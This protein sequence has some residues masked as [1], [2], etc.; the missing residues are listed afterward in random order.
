MNIVI[1]LAGHSRRFLQAGYEI[2]KFLIDIDGV[3]MIQH[4]V[5]MF[6][7]LDNFYFVVNRE[8]IEA[9]PFIPAV[10][11][12]L[13]KKT[14]I[15]IIE[16][17]E[18]G[19]VW[20]ALQVTDIPANDEMIV[21]YCDF[22]VTWDYKQFKR[23][24]YGYD[25][26]VPA[27]RGFHPASFGNTYYAYMR[28][29]DQQEML[30]LREKN[31]FTDK[32]H[33][34]FASAGIYYFSSWTLFKHYAERLMEKGYADS[35]L[36]EGYASLL[37]NP[38]V[39]D[40]YKVKVTEV[41]QF[42]CW[43]TPEDLA[44]YQFWSRYFKSL[45]HQSVAPSQPMKSINLIPM[46]GSGSR[47]KEYGYRVGKPLILIRNKPMVTCAC[48]SFPKADDWIF[49]P[50]QED[51]A[52]H[53][54]DVVIKS[55][56]PQALV[57]P[58]AGNTS[59]Q[60]ATCLLAKND[61]DPDASLFIASCDYEVCFNAAAWQAIVDDETI[62]AVIWTYRMKDALA[63]N[64]MAFAYC[65]TERDSARVKKI[66]EK[67]TISDQPCQDPLVVGSFWFRRA[68]DFIWAAETAVKNNV[69]VNGEHY[70]ANSMNALIEKGDKIVI[71]DVDQWI[72]FGDP[73]ELNVYYY[74]DEYF[75]NTSSR[76]PLNE[77]RI[78]ESQSS[79]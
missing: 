1:T 4:V 5:S 40:G 34:E 26:A 39:N 49:L 77:S 35:N 43:G 32:R 52:K 73:F 6:D 55:M 59:G 3:P 18:L 24:I 2:P 58:V 12:S 14:K 9:F 13:A 31:S 38:L 53:D 41:D 46:A 10:L 61:M 29:N 68:R 57:I 45:P 20:S 71:F 42:I 22:Y 79:I 54:I 44:Q 69:T 17:H 75:S 64:P 48:E 70:V 67:Q 56:I 72:S 28:V 19:P 78:I 76:A 74:W 60:A 66:V 30:E 37:F 21:S 25:G 27:F 7:A 63:K 33:E 65:Q 36:K 51:L 62:D 8:Q 47:F 11:T 16:P 15:T 23:Q 50:R